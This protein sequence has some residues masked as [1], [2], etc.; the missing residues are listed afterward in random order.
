MDAQEVVQ[1]VENLQKNVLVG[2]LVLIYYLIVYWQRIK[3]GLG[4][5]HDKRNNLDRIVKSYQLL[6]LRLEIEKIKKDSGLDRALLER[7]ELEL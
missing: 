4:L 1:V 3:D 6:K 2:I 7:L 5:S